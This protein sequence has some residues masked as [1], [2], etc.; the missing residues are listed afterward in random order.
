MGREWDRQFITGR[1]F[2]I[3]SGFQFCTVVNT[4][5]GGVVNAS[6]YAGDPRMLDC[7]LPEGHAGDH[8]D[9]AWDL[10]WRVEPVAVGSF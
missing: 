9:E 3:E 8:W 4:A 1:D 7:C 6:D 5:I 10:A 2:P